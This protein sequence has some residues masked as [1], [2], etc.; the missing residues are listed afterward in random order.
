MWDD[1]DIL[2]RVLAVSQQEYL[3]NL[4]KQHDEHKEETDKKYVCD[5]NKPSTSQ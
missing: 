3:Q 2:T 4:K 1:I 5:V